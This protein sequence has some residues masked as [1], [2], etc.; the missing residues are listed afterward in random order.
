MRMRGNP[1]QMLFF[2]EFTEIDD[3]LGTV[4]FYVILNDGTSVAKLVLPPTIALNERRK[5]MSSKLSLDVIY[6]YLPHS[7]SSFRLENFEQD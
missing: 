2:V 6:F 7:D 5:R 4:S 3:C 1:F